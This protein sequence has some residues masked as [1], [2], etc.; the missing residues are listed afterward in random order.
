[1]GSARRP[2][3]DKSPASSARW[4]CSGS[5][6]VLFRAMP[7]DLSAWASCAFQVLPL[8]H[9][10]VVQELRAAQPAE[11][12]G[13]QRVLLL[14]QIGPEVEV[15]Q[16]VRGRIAEPRVRGV[17]LLLRV[18]R[19][20]A[21]VLDRQCGGDHEH[22]VHAAEA[23][24]LEQHP[25]D[26][27]VDGQLREPAPDVSEPLGV[28]RAQLLQQLHPV[29]NLPP[30]GRVQE[31]KFG[32]VAES[33]RGHLQ[34]DRGQVGAQDLRVGELRPGEEVVLGVQPDAD[35]V[36]DPA[37]SPL[38]L[39]GAGLAHRLDRESLHLGA[40]AVPGDSR[41]ARVDHIPDAGHG[42]RRL[43]DVGAEDDPASLV[44]GEHLVLLGGCEPRIQRE[45]LGVPDMHA[46]QG[47]RCVLDLAFARQE[48]Q[49]VAVQ[50]RE[51]ADRVADGLGLVGL[52]VDRAVE[53]LDRVGAT[54]HLDDRGVVEV[55]RKPSRVD[56]GAGDDDLEIGTLRKQ[57]L[58]VA[59]QEVDVEAAL[60]RLV[61]DDRVVAEQHA[62]TLDLGQQD[63]VGHHLD[64]GALARFVGEAHLVADGVRGGEL[65]GDPVGHRAGGDPPRLG[66]ADCA[67]HATTK[68]ETDL[69]DLGGLA[70]SGLAGD[71][72][73][74]VVTD[75]GQDVVLAVGDRKLVWIADRRDAGS[76]LGNASLGRGD[77]ALKRGQQ[78]SVGGRSSGG[79]RAAV[80]P[81]D[82]GRAP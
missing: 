64:Q 77:V 75:R 66:V 68:L 40:V 34:D 52:L 41:G 60:V 4:M 54:G 10:Q 71:D 47:I 79:L 27:R 42:E 16:E 28:E 45:D 57:L 80:D 17:R 2:M 62:V 1:M 22:L 19:S 32:D 58:Q 48:H 51:L 33:Q 26:A 11:G 20:L 61:D 63:A 18:R 65:L 38:A 69:R 8:A 70:G 74:L 29:A 6:A 43:G 9:P 31:R 50:R 14:L 35:A 39:V 12:A 3:C 73:D 13:R 5:D 37:A 72:D 53:D 81:V 44:G 25:A 7:S 67:E 55:P 23:I 78:A 56:G 82:A 30:V 21:R 59:E 49:D 24:G 15:S 46:T 36:G 76:A